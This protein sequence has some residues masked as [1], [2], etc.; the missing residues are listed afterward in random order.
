MTNNIIKLDRVLVI[1]DDPFQQ[2]LIKF[3]LDEIAT[4]IDIAPDGQTAMDK[5]KKNDYDCL[6]LDIGLPD[7]PG[8]DVALFYR[9][10][11]PSSKAPVIIFSAHLGDVNIDALL[12][13]GTITGAFSKPVS[14]DKMQDILI[15]HMA[16]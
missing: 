7:R 10:Q 6:I 1:E 3:V 11:Y 5:I 2:K 16:N 8:T 9:K 13:D 4:S 14:M 12:N 15:K